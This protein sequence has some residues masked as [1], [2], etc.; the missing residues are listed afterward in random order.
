MPDLRKRAVSGSSPSTWSMGAAPAPG[1]AGWPS[2]A[3]AVQPLWRIARLLQALF[4]TIARALSQ[5]GLGRL[6]KLEPKPAV[7][8][9]E[10]ERL[11]DLIHVD[12]K[13]KASAQQ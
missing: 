9:Y 7:Q 13:P 12:V 11:G 1:T 10:W 6:R 8:R 4:S 2:T 5:L 3:Q